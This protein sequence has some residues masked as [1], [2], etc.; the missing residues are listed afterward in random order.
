M[1]MKTYIFA[2][3]A[4]II[5]GSILDVPLA[6]AEPANLIENPSVEVAGI[7]GD[8]AG[9]YRGFWGENN[10]TFNYP[11]SRDASEKAARVE[12]SSYISGD[13][14]WYFEDVPVEGGATYTFSQKFNSGG[15]TLD[16][17]LIARFNMPEG[18]IYLQ[19]G[20]YT[21]KL[22]WEEI[23]VHVRAPHG[24]TSMTIFHI[25]ENRGYLEIDDSVLWKD[26]TIPVVS[27]DSPKNGA[28]VSGI[29]QIPI[30]A[31]DDDAVVATALALDGEL[32]AVDESAPFIFDLD[33]TTVTDGEHDL[34]ALA[35]DA[36][37][38]VAFSNLVNIIVD[39]APV[40]NTGTSDNLVLNPLLEEAGPNGDPKHW[41]RGGWGN[42]D[43]TFI[44]PVSIGVPGI[45][46]ITTSARV[47]IANYVDGDAKWYFEDIPVE[48]GVDYF[49]TSY[50]KSN[51]ET[52][53]VAR[54][55]MEDG[56]VR[57][58]HITNLAA[59]SEYRRLAHPIST[60]DG[61]ISMTIFHLL[62]SNGYLEVTYFDVH[63]PDSTFPRINIL[64]PNTGDTVSGPVIV[65]VDVSDDTGIQSVTYFIDGRRFVGV[66]STPF[67]FNAWDTMGLVDGEHAII[68]MARDIDGNETLSAPVTV[69]VNNSK[70]SNIGNSTQVHDIA[71]SIIS[72]PMLEEV[73]TDGSPAKWNTEVL[74]GSAAEFIYPISGGDGSYAWKVN[75]TDYK[76]NGPAGWYTNPIPV[77]GGQNYYFSVQYRS[78][79]VSNLYIQ[80]DTSQGISNLLHLKTLLRSSEW[81]YANPF[82]ISVPEDAHSVTIHYRITGYGTLEFDN[83][84]L[85]ETP[86][87]VPGAPNLVLNPSLEIAGANGDPEYWL[88]GGWGSNDRT[89]SY[90][91]PGVEGASAARVE[92]QNYVDGDAKWY[93]EDIALAIGQTHVVKHSYRSSVPSE[94]VVR[95]VM[96][97][98][99]YRYAFVKSYGSTDGVWVEDSLEI[100]PIAGARSTTLFHLISNN[101]WLEID[102]YSIVAEG[103]G[104]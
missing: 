43:R 37:D 25:L 98:Y 35:I 83:M 72:N 33:T 16:T 11:I 58:Q 5:I 36:S 2:A 65:D 67:W 102:N 93:F 77:N 21:P 90:P 46:A 63:R 91:V 81:T 85:S 34:F 55:T 104:P 71:A 103:P 86:F 51:V 101:G 92:I 6:H 38:N 9:W 70:P 62:R 52:E 54:F 59:F 94:F 47:E 17:K 29:I 73:G 39:N 53:I 7:N 12:I 50:F 23:S 96:N 100:V 88:S 99:S 66:A 13:A 44:Y 57:Y 32:Y 4:A 14:K 68:A 24:A 15:S 8:P 49:Y 45:S 78:L 1:T 60:P 74:G 41:F 64:S 20:A 27:I 10:A 89:Y 61:S 97:D 79:D 30:D 28:T 19:L 40:A 82:T 42:N 3:F 26:T 56:T 76:N 95:Y 84:I 69:F 22:Q 31:S 87:D 18:Y 75:L 80:Y 48:G